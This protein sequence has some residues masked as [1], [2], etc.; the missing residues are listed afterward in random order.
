MSGALP[1]RISEGTFFLYLA[2]DNDK[3]KDKDN[4]KYKDKDKNQRTLFV[5]FWT[6]IQSL[7]CLVTH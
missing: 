6:E 2:Y 1:T 4:D 7:P 5:L 3:D